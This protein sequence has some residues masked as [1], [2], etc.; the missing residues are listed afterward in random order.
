MPEGLNDLRGNVSDRSPFPGWHSFF[1]LYAAKLGDKT[2]GY[3]YLDNRLGSEA[4]P[5]SHLPYVRLLCN[6]IAIRL[7]NIN[8]YNEIREMKDRFERKLNLL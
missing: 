2:Y 8:I 7:S 6:Q 5:D 1:Y 3:L 4:F